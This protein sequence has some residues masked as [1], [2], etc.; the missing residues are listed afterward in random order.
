MGR[1]GVFGVVVRE[2]GVRLRPAREYP[3]DDYPRMHLHSKKPSPV[4]GGLRV[5]Q[6]PTAAQDLATHMVP[7]G[8]CRFGIVFLP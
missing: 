5:D 4:A 8:P 1:E 6:H 3:R 7:Y 2:T